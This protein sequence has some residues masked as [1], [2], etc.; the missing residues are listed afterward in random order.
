MT[1]INF[2]IKSLNKETLFHYKI[3]L[4]KIFNMQGIKTSCFLLP[5]KNKKTNCIEIYACI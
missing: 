5:K 4:V 2:E 3:F 1:Q